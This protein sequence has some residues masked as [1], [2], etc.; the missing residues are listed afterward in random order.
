MDNIYSWGVNGSSRLL[1][2]ST[3]SVLN[4]YLHIYQSIHNNGHNNFGLAILEDLDETNCLNK[5]FLLEPEFYSYLLF[6]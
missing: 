4:R 6:F 5:K 2:Y 1:S 3:H